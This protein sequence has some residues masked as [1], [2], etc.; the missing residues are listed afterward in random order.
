MV[1]PAQRALLWI[2]VGMA[3]LPGSRSFAAD[4]PFL[5][6]PAFDGSSAEIGLTDWG[7]KPP[8]IAWT[9]TLGQGYSACVVAEGR[10]YTQYQDAWGQYLLALRLTDGQPVW[11]KKYAAPYDA[12]SIYP[13]PRST[14]TYAD[15]RVYYT[16]PQ[17]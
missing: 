12:V 7:D 17:A 1:N 13:G 5:R 14:P 4:W 10:V 6:G 8:T 3:C 16:T 2:A 9:H 11:K 15:G